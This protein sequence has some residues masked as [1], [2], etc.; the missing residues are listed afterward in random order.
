MVALVGSDAGL[1]NI[2][3]IGCGRIARSVHLKILRNTPAVRITAI[4]EPDTNTH[5][6]ARHLAPDACLSTHYDSL[7]ARDDVDAVLLALPTGQHAEAALAAFAAGKHVYLE[8]PLA[9]NLADAETVLEAW[10]RADRVGMI[11]FNYRFNQLCRRARELLRQ[12]ALGELIA[13][14][15]VFSSAMRPLPPWKTRRAT[16]GGVL[17]DLASHH[18]D[19]VR[20]LFDTDVLDVTCDLQS[21]VTEDD[22]AFLTMLAANGATVQSFFSSC[23]N[24]EDRFEIHGS[25]GEM[26]IDRCHG[27]DVTRRGP[28]DATHRADQMRHWARSIRGLGYGL[29]RWRSIGHEPSW[30]L[31][32]EHFISAVRGEH[33][34][35]PTLRDGYE[36][37]KVVVAAEEAARSR[38]LQ[39]A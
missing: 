34:A 27:M 23:A 19:L 7:L 4:A 26:T 9:T 11:G 39:L 3:L 10:R 8:K 36:S 21:R 16:G 32:L 12:G 13:V 29:A 17:L 25:A 20:F 5:S 24:D 28:H 14:R 38:K 15:S 30:Q 37:L 1:V 18:I 6:E 31:A 2:G 35:E 22:T 33:P